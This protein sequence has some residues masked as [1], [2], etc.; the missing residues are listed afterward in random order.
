MPPRGKTGS[1]A[2]VRGTRLT[3]GFGLVN[4]DVRLA[5]L[6]RSDSGRVAGKTLC[7][8]HHAPIRTQPVCEECGGPCETETGY[9]ADGGYVVVDKD[10]L[11]ADR[12]GRLELT[13]VL[14]VRAVDPFYFEKPYMVWPQ[15][16]SE[17]G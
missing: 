8:V 6:V 15:E 13:A 7:T 4:V 2:P 1:P 10:A 5:P 14:D 3:F 11:G 12:T 9:E 17:V 16:G